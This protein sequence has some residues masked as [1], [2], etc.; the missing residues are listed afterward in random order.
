[1]FLLEANL[2]TPKE[3]FLLET[4]SGGTPHWHDWFQEEVSCDTFVFSTLCK[5]P[6]LGTF[7]SMMSHK[8]F[9]YLLYRVKHSLVD[10]VYQPWYIGGTISRHLLVGSGLRSKGWV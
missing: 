1:M 2:L 3:S 8:W 4:A 7:G 10:T 9:L 6:H 5:E